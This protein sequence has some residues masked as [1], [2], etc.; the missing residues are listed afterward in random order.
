MAGKQVLT[1]AEIDKV[2]AVSRRTLLFGPPGTGK[3][4][5]G[6]HSGLSKKQRVF[7]V[8][9]TEET[10]AAQLMGHFVPSGDRWLWMDG[11]LVAAW[12]C[13]GRLVLNEIDRASGDAQ[14]LCYAIL[15]DPEFAQLTLPNMDEDGNGELIRPA[16][17]FSAVATMNGELEDIPEAL[18]D[19]MLSIRIEEVNPAAIAALP[20]SLHKAAANGSK[21]TEGRVSI[22]SWG[23]FAYLAST[24]DQ[25]LAAKAVFRERHKDVLTA[26]RLV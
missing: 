12:R 15:D 3:T 20:E 19:R 21:V 8:T 25:E 13:G 10:S 11:P 2:M 7:S 9:L 17:G 23:M 1:W 26:I 5:L 24:L 16:D 18:Q 14:T 22:R 6:T 4:Y